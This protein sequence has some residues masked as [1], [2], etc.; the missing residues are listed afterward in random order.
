MLGAAKTGQVTVAMSDTGVPMHWP[1]PV[2]VKLDVIEQPA[3]A[4]TV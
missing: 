4:G 1:L 3:S 2:A